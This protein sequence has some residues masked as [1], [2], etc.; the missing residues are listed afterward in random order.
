[1]VGLICIVHIARAFD[2]T[3]QCS[4]F[5]GVCQMVPKRYGNAT[6]IAPLYVTGQ[7]VW[8]L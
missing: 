1:M 3:G 4:G 6:V 2:V 5:L 7:V 8:D